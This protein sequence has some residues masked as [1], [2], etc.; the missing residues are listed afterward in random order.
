MRGLIY[1]DFY[2]IRGKMIATLIMIGA[3]II[4]MSIIIIASGG[5]SGINVAWGNMI[6]DIMIVLYL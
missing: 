1:K 2:L 4:I 3:M 6:L 5:S